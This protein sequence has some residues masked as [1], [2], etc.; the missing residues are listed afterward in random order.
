MECWGPSFSDS[1]GGV[2]HLWDG[3]GI[4]WAIWDL[5]CWKSWSFFPCS[6]LLFYTIINFLKISQS[7]YIYIYN[8]KQLEEEEEEENWSKRKPWRINGRER[9]R[10]LV[11]LKEEKWERV[12]IYTYMDINIIQTQLWLETLVC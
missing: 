8:L 1:E 9:R 2:L 4:Q 7:R 12:Y 11:W 6:I 5:H 3:S 10:R